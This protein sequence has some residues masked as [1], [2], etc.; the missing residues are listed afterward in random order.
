MLTS[1]FGIRLMLLVGENVPR[2]ASYGAM[3]AIT[4]VEVSIREDTAD[5]FQITLTLGKERGGEYSLLKSGELALFNRV[6]IAVVMGVMPEVIIDGIITNHQVTPSDDPGKSTL[7]VTGTDLSKMM[8]LEERTV[9]HDNQSSSMIVERILSKYAKYGVVPSLTQTNDVQSNL[10][11]IPWQQGTDLDCIQNLA[12]DNGF[13]FYIEPLTIG[14]ST[15]YWGP[16]IRTG[17]LQP[18][19]SIGMGG[20]TNLRSL[21]FSEEALSTASIMARF[22]EPLAKAAIA[23]PVVSPLRMPPMAGTATSSKKVTILRDTANKGAADALLAMMSAMT[24]QQD[25][26]A[27]SGEL[28]SVRYGHVLR[29]RQLVGV[30]GAGKSHD[31]IYYVKGVSHRLS[32]G[33]Y[34]QSFTLGREGTGAISPVVMT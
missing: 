12:K 19:L 7:T 30:R 27:G 29:A 10:E 1:Q 24:N 6:I 17:M 9:P 28:D 21:N 20:A 23:L 34:T 31:G 32:R 16:K 2:P 3:S 8:D 4:Q 25:S 5:G 22:I 33:E 13:V 11:R 14:K 18:A 26:A 15:A